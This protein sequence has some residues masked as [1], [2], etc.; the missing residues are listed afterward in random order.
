MRN[1]GKLQSGVAHHRFRPVFRRARAVPAR[2][3]VVS[4]RDSEWDKEVAAMERVCR[5]IAESLQNTIRTLDDILKRTDLA[6][7]GIA[8]DKRLTQELLREMGFG[9]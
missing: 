7:A 9:R 6:L 8:E 2:V 1:P 5:E 3:P 4:E